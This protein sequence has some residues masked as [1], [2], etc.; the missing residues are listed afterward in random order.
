MTN[1]IKRLDYKTIAMNK[2]GVT[3]ILSKRL[4]SLNLKSWYI[5][6]GEIYA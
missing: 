5:I 1:T 4:S 2:D 6:D 3:K